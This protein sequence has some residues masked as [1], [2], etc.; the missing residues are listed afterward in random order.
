MFF[1]YV[2]FGRCKDLRRLCIADWYGKNATT[3]KEKKRGAGGGEP[4]A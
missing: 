4:S 2:Y 1:C 3:R